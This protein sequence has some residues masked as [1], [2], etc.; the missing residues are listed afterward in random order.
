MIISINKVAKRYSGVWILK[1][2]SG[3]FS[4]PNVVAII[5]RNGE[6]K[7]TLVKIVSGVVKADGGSVFIDG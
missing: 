5:G 7:S 2:G 4:S 6:G 1:E 3:E